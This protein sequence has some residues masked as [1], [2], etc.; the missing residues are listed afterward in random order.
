MHKLDQVK[1]GGGS[2]N[3]SVEACIW[4]PLHSA[5]QMSLKHKSTGPLRPSVDPQDQI[6]SLLPRGLNSGFLSS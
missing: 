1:A 3:S 6:L 2:C 5:M 4:S